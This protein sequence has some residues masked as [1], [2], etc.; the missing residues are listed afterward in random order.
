MRILIL[1]G[2]VFVGRHLTEAALENGHEVT[3]FNRGR[4]NQDLFPDVEKLKGDRSDDLEALKDREWDVVIDA[5]GYTPSQATAAAE[6]LKDSVKRY[7]FISS[8][9]AYRDFHEKYVDETYPVGQLEDETTEEVNAQTYG[10]LKALAEKKLEEVMPG[11]V[12]NIRPGII[13]GP[14]DPTDR[15][16]YW[17]MRFGRGGEVLVPGKQ[18]R[19]IQWIDAR[20]L[21]KWIIQMAEQEETG[22]YNAV[23]YDEE[24]TMKTFVDALIKQNP[25]A[26]DQW[27]SDQ[28]LLDNEAKPSSDLPLWI[29]VS[30]DHPHG[31]ILASN[32]KAREKGL[33]FR[34]LEETIEDTRKWFEEREDTDMR[35][36]IEPDK[37]ATIVRRCK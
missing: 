17:V 25:N 2:T 8:I 19:P 21:S 5:S 20:D 11:R 31:F 7:I 12:L 10:P 3:L 13:V 37:E 4:T 29:P 1:G 34:K 27:I 15:F 33:T 36:G 35:V 26:E 23:G 32:K 28:C 22:T 9:S 18:N 30:E 14:H 24:L 16:T 6:L